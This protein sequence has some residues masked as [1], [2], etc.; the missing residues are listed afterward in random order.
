MGGKPATSYVAIHDDLGVIYMERVGGNNTT[1]WCSF[2]DRG[3]S[4]RSVGGFYPYLVNPWLTV[5]VS[6]ETFEARCK[7]A[8][9]K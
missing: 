5:P 3:G 2:T 8:A 7:W 9:R 6:R 4:Y 1:N